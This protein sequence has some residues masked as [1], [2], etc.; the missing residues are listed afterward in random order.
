MLDAGDGVSALL[1]QKSR[2]I[3]S[4]FITHADRDHICGL[5]QFHQLNAREGIPH[6][7]YPK[8]SGSFPALRD[9]VERFDPQSGPA[10]W[11]G[12]KEG[13]TIDLQGGFSV[14]AQSSD[15]INAG[16]VTKALNYT[17]CRTRR[18][19]KTEFIG[20][21]GRRIA[22]IRKEHG[23]SFISETRVEKIIGYSGDAS[24]LNPAQWEGVRILIHEATFLKPD[25]AKNAHANIADVIQAAATMNL[26]ALV[27]MHF[28]ARYSK[29]EILAAIVREAQEC[30]LTFPVFAAFPCQL[31]VDILS[32]EPVWNPLNQ[33][34]K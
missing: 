7:Y 31:S 21:D 17:V 19:L 32:S 9:F 15:H 25:T 30:D 8:D 13:D 1:E 22:E 16:N 11:A 4:I 3:R 34:S 2:K 12:V 29:N 33:P 20:L 27:L 28:S 6:I 18:S 26:E 14:L 10:S 5:L 23:D 24:K